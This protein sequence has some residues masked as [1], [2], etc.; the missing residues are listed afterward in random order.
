MAYRRGQKP[1]RDVYDERFSEM[2]SREVTSHRVV[3]IVDKRSHMPRPHMEFERGF[4]DDQWY[5]GPRNYQDA[6]EYEEGSFPPNDRRYFDDNSHGNFRRNTPQNEGHYSQ[7]S[8]D[9]DDLRHHLGSSSGR[10]R[11]YYR[12]RGRVSGP[13]LRNSPPAKRDRSPGRREAHPPVAVRAGSNSSNRSFSPDREKNFNYQ[14][15]QQRHK[16]S[17]LKSHT[18][19]SSVEETPHSSGSSKEKTPASVAETEEVVAAS[20]EPKP[21]PEEDFKAR[22][23]EA[24]KAKALEIEKHYRKDCETFRTVV[25]M[26]VAKEPSLD[27]VLQAPLDENLL[28]I[29]QRCLDA[30]RHFVKELDEVL[31]Q[32]DTSA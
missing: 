10:S 30:L 17:V 31:Q 14:Q 25:N 28:E 22:R 26:L 1:I 32:T 11:P 4:N 8:Y 18:P 27:N 24:I 12:S 16:P 29:K 9:R 7:Q 3:N 19:S 6:R 23:S 2:D 20:M 21:T 5:D 13:P 15:A